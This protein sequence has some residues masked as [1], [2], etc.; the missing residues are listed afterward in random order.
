MTDSVARRYCGLCTFADRAGETVVDGK[1]PAFRP[2]PSLITHSDSDDSV[3]GDTLEYDPSTWVLRDIRVFHSVCYNW[4]G[5]V[6]PQLR[7][8][9]QCDW[10]P[11]QD[12]LADTQHGRLG[13]RKTLA[14]PPYRLPLELGHYVADHLVPYYHA[15]ATAALKVDSRRVMRIDLSR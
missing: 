13:M 14:K 8:L 6:S 4:V 9:T 11:M 10:T 12:A 7:A 15:A 5:G 2:K 1:A 3:E